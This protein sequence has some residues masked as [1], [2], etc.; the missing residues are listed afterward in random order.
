VLGVQYPHFAGMGIKQPIVIPLLKKHNVYSL[1]MKNYRPGANSSFVS[2]LLVRVVQLQLQSHLISNGLMPP[3]QS[4]YLVN[5]SSEIALLKIFNDML[6]AA[7]R[8]EATAL[9]MLNL[10]TSFD[11]VD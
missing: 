8:G 6:M 11:T 4:A 1:E 2:K 7:D 9:C 10:S 5:Y 3:I